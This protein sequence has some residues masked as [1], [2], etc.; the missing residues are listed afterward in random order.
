MTKIISIS[1][2]LDLILK[3]KVLKFHKFQG[4]NQIITFDN[5]SRGLLPTFNRYHRQV[6]L[7]FRD[8]FLR[9][10]KNAWISKLLISWNAVT[11]KNEWI[12]PSSI[13]Y[14]MQLLRIENQN[15][16]KIVLLIFFVN[17]NVK[18]YYH[19][20]R[21]NAQPCCSLCRLA[22]VRFSWN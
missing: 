4:L 2:G 20:I 19:L 15:F 1:L 12:I 22:K 14:F 3:L 6:D 9:I 17:K 11:D 16:A 7:A 5:L 10:D 18:I 21:F 13:R 8:L